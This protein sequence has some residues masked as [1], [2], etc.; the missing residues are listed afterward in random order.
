MGEG[1]R[2]LYVK[3][4]RGLKRGMPPSRLLDLTY[5]RLY[6]DRVATMRSFKM[7]KEAHVGNFGLMREEA[8]AGKADS[9]TTIR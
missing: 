8:L 1:R 4:E 3:I 5:P 9:Q 6:I 2:Q 7:L